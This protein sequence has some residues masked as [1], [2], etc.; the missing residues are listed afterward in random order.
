LVHQIQQVLHHPAVVA[1]MMMMMVAEIAAAG[2]QRELAAHPAR[3]ALMAP[4]AE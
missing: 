2:R 1:V 4:V 3:V